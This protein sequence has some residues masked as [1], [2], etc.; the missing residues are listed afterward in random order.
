YMCSYTAPMFTEIAQT[1]GVTLPAGALMVTSFNIL[2]KPIFGLIFLAF[3]S[4]NPLWIG[5][6]IV[7]YFVVYFLFRK[8]KEAFYGYVERAAAKNS[9][10]IPEGKTKVA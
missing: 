7:A 9:G 5:L 4:Q 8:N 10:E 1:V 3:L 6:T 2:G